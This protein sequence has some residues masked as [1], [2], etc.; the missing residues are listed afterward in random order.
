MPPSKN[1]VNFQD[2]AVIVWRGSVALESPCS[3]GRTPLVPRS[4]RHRWPECQEPA[5]ARRPEPYSTRAPTC[6]ACKCREYRQ[7]DVVLLWAKRD[8]PVEERVQGLI[9]IYPAFPAGM[10]GWINT[11]IT[12][13]IVIGIIHERK[14]IR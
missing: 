10:G 4:G 3:R 11:K 5:E 13:A 6:P 9:D 1:F 2:H 12:V 14:T 8:F 7:H